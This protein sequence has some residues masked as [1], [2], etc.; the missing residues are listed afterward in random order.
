MK[1]AGK[2][3]MRTSFRNGGRKA[4]MGMRYDDYSEESG[5]TYGEKRRPSVRFPLDNINPQDLN[6]EVIIV[7]KGRKNAAD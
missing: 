1:N 6:G 4:G 5:N 7:Q 3:Y 2:Q